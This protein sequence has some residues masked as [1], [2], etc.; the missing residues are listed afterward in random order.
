MYLDI[1]YPRRIII[2]A[3]CVVDDN[4]D[5]YIDDKDKFYYD[6]SSTDCGGENGFVEEI[7]LDKQVKIKE[8]RSYSGDSEKIEPKIYMEYVRPEPTFWVSNADLEVMTFKK[9]EIDISDIRERFKRTIIIWTT[10]QFAEK[11]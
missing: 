5:D 7:T 10:G 2:Y 9:I 3:D 1:N 11:E 6:P 4:G 8:I